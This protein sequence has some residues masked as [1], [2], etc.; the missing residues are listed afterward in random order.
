M[1]DLLTTFTG[2]IRRVAH[3]DDLRWKLSNDAQTIRV[4]FMR[5]TRWESGVSS[6][7]LDI[8][9]VLR[10]AIR[11]AHRDTAGVDYVVRRV[12]RVST[13]ND[14]RVARQMAAGRTRLAS[15]A[16]GAR[17]GEIS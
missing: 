12:E 10:V 13:A 17:G 2:A 3:G 7:T 14:Q 6:Q 5:D 11:R 1:S 4:A 9:D 16:L 15:Q 8:G